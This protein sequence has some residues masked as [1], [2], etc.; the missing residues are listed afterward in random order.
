[1]NLFNSSLF[2]FSQNNFTILVQIPLFTL[3]L[4]IQNSLYEFWKEFVW[5]VP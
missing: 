4:Q 5:N 2:L 3:G 1:M